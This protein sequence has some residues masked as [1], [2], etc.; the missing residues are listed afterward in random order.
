MKKNN[1]YLTP[2]T[3]EIDDKYLK[4]I[5]VKKKERKK[6]NYYVLRAKSSP[7]VQRAPKLT[8]AYSSELALLG[9]EFPSGNENTTLTTIY[10]PRFRLPVSLS[11]ITAEREVGRGASNTDKRGR[12]VIAEA[13]LAEKGPRLEGEAQ[14]AEIPLNELCTRLVGETSQRD[15]FE[16]SLKRLVPPVSQSVNLSAWHWRDSSRGREG[17]K[18][19]EREK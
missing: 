15:T 2:Q 16:D 12:G 1:K 19:R 17:E 13:D 10:L 6:N 8:Y 4:I 5:L 18:E 14:R 9:A 3:F 7:D 11:A